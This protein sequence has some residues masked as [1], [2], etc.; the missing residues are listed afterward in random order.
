MSSF[1]LF[2]LFMFDVLDKTASEKASSVD[3]E[4]I[5]PKR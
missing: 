1:D 4:S 2:L 5:F 3:F